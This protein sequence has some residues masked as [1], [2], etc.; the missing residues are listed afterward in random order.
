MDL[1]K[2]TIPQ[3]LTISFLTVIL[4]GSLLLSLPIMHQPGA[5]TTYLDHLFTTVSMVCV[6]GLMVITVGDV[7]NTMGQVICIILMQIGGLGLITLLSAST[8]Y[9]KRKLSLK[10]QYTLQASFSHED[11]R[12][13]KPLLISIYRFT[14]VVEGGAALLL[15]FSFV[16]KFGLFKGIF[17]A[18]FIAVSAF[19]NAGFDNLGT[20]SLQA[21][22]DD[23]YINLIVCGLIISGGIGFIV[24][25][26]VGNMVHSYLCARPRVWR[27]SVRHLSVHAHLV[28]K[29]TFIVLL[30]GTI[31]SW[32]TEWGNPNTI[33]NFPLGKQ[34]LISFF[35]AVTMRTAG[36]ATIDYTMTRPI[37]NLLYIVQMAMGG[38]PG[39]TAGGIK[40]TTAAILF[41][42]FKAEF[43]GEYGIHYRRR[44][45]TMR[46]IRQVIVVV[47]F[48]FSVYVI[49]FG[50]LLLTQPHISPY[51]LLFET[52][53]AL[54]TVGVT[55]NATGSLN[56]IG[57]IIIIFLMFLGRVGPTTV[58]LS[59]ATKTKKE[60]Q[61][62]ATD[63]YIG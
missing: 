31:L 38:A 30:S 63:V 47:V 4:V 36:F 48:F 58:L 54:A 7:Y 42:I 3:R 25:F 60:I 26:E 6:T 27:N 17:N 22:V 24:W 20:T 46:L 13:L 61:Y 49:G 62:A 29:S 5:V 11:N 50:L 23:P 37:T 44:A 55:M 32:I 52:T 35:N 16:P 1:K 14:A 33:A 10:D 34:A 43:K 40:I 18:I 21:Y 53:S 15:S 9:L 59:L 19:C 45:F 51:A 41:L 57:Q 39:G 56:E 8:F 28:F 2:L 12:E